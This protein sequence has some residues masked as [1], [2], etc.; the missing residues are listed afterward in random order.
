[1]SLVGKR[2]PD[3][4]LQSTSGTEISLSREPGRVVVFCYPYTGR[5]GVA[6]PPGWDDIAGA[7][8]STPQALAFSTLYDG[9][10]THGVKLFGLSLQTTAW[11]QEF[12]SRNHL[13]FALLSDEKHLF[14]KALK[15]STFKAGEEEFLLRRTF[16]SHHGVI[17]HDVFPVPDPVANAQT[18]LD[19]FRT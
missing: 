2:C 12:V 17:T 7:H 5:P 4:W 14:S 6:D 9:F 16:V 8:G 11:Q 19:M 10:A 15:L 18:V 3:I 1:V 13:Q